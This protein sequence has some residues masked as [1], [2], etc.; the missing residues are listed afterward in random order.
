MK[1]VVQPAEG[2]SSTFEMRGAF[3]LAEKRLS[4][5]GLDIFPDVVDRGNTALVEF[6]Y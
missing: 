5:E 1:K 6:A 2:L 3:R 4:I